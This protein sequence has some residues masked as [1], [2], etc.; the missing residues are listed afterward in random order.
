VVVK[1]HV[2]PSRVDE[3]VGAGQVQHVD[4]V[5]RWRVEQVLLASV[6]AL[7]VLM[8][9]PGWYK[10]T[11]VH[12]AGVLGMLVVQKRTQATL[13]A[14]ETVCM[15]R[16]RWCILWSLLSSEMHLIWSSSCSQVTLS[17]EHKARGGG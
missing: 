9:V 3:S 16:V 1:V 2:G 4:G 10:P 5:L 12:S 17:P 14:R 15:L 7:G 13:F 11:L 8:S 6:R